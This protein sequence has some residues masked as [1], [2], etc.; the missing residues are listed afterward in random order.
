MYDCSDDHCTEKEVVELYDTPPYEN[1]GIE[2]ASVNLI[3]FDKTDLL[4]PGKSQTLSLTAV[5]IHW[6]AILFMMNPIRMQAIRWL[7]P[8]S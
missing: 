7:H 3:A 5:H 6:T 2:K 8:I 1:G 4:E